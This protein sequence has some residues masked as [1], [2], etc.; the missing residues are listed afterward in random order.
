MKR[1]LF[2]LLVFSFLFSKAQIS[3]TNSHMPKGGDTLRYSTAILDSAILLNFAKSGANQTWQ[4]D[5]LI[6]QRQGLRRFDL[7]SQTPYSFQVPNRIGEKL[8][9]TLSLGQVELIN[10]YDFF[11]S[12]TNSYSTTHRGFT[13]GAFPFPIAQSFQN[14]DEVY[15][16]PLNYLDRDSS[17]FKFEFN[18]IIPPAYYK[19]EGYRINEVDAWGSITTPYGTFNCIRV[20]VDIV[21][22][23]TVQFN[24]NGFS[25]DNHRREYQWLS[26]QEA[27]PILT[28]GGV[29]I[30]NQFAPATVSY[31]DSARAVPSIFAPIALFN[32]DTTAY[33][34]GEVVKFNNLS[35]SLLAAS[36][37]W[38]IEP[39]TFQ[40]VNGSNQNSDSIAVTFTD[41]GLYTV[42]LIAR[43]SAGRD[44]LERNNYLR[45]LEPNG[46]SEN[47]LDFK[48]Q[49]FPNPL[50]RANP[51]F[52]EVLENK[53]IQVLRLFDLSGKLV[54]N[55]A[56]K[57][58]DS[59]QF[60][61]PANLP[62]GTYFLQLESEDQFSTVKLIVQ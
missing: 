55:Q 41:T 9:D 10:V 35:I 11:N 19:S 52:I 40:F 33:R 4:F 26:Q 29:V 49:V 6:P 17:T 59:F 46:L 23:D 3:I 28:V 16:F 18:N 34:A 27:I 51:L 39:N 1:S 44:T 62:T 54:L 50:R 7:S 22:S 20:I 57:N 47:N 61:L 24:G 58:K 45:I 2:I 48:V 37:T 32:S 30:G 60:S 21:S 38:Q 56:I 25:I 5:S 36:Y 15:Q 53:E 8:A 42:R 12:T 31:R 14:P 13:L 43:N